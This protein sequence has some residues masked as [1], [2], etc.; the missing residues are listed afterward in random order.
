M[1][2][3]SWLKAGKKNPYRGLTDDGNSVGEAKRKKK[4]EKLHTLEMML[5]QIANFCP[6]IAWNAIVKK[7]TSL[8]HIWQVIRLHYGFQSSGAHF[9]DLA[10]VT[11][12]PEEK[13]EDLYQRLLAFI[14][15]N[16]VRKD[17]NI[18]HHGDK[19]D[20]DEELSP[21]LVFNPAFKGYNNAA[22][23][24]EAVMNM[25]PTQPPQRKDRLP[26]FNRDCLEELQ[27]KFDQLESMGVFKRPEDI[28]VCVEYV[29]P[30]FLVKKSNGG[31]RLVTVFFRLRTL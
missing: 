21:T 13:P 19:P 7:F 27:A 9:L 28:G 25:G 11:L 1:N 29:N 2:G 22:D 31:H 4:D 17:S 20:D 26:Q 12:D 3:L 5:G 14:E 6:I 18:T 10:D 23:Q 30:S 16:L 15:D 24:F 8:A